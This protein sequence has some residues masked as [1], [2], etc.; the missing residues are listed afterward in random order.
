MQRCSDELVDLAPLLQ[1]SIGS[2]V[3]LAMET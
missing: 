2:C 1:D 3:V